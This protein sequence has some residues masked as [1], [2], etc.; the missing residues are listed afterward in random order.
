[1][2]WKIFIGYDIEILIGVPKIVLLLLSSVVLWNTQCVEGQKI[3]VSNNNGNIN[4]Y[5][6]EPSGHDFILVILG[7]MQCIYSV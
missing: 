5:W 1:M 4:I 3:I 6:K 7:L 2:A